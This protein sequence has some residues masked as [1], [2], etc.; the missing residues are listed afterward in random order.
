MNRKRKETDRTEAPMVKRQRRKK[1]MPTP[2]IEAPT[3]GCPIM[4]LVDDCFYEICRKLSPDDICA[5]SQTCDRFKSLTWN[6]FSH[7][8]Q[9]KVMVIE[10]IS[11]EGKLLVGPKN[12]KYIG[13]FEN[14]IQSVVLNAN[15]KKSL[16]QLYEIYHSAER[17]PITA[18]KF[19]DWDKLNRAKGI[20][21]G[22]ILRSVEAVT[23]FRTEIDGDLNQCLLR[24][25]PY[26]KR[27]TLFKEFFAPDEIEF[28]WMEETYENLQY[29]AW[30]LDEELPVATAKAFFAANPQ[31]TFFSLLASQSHTL[32]SLLAES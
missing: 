28:D 26:M 18:V 11:K 20:M 27:L 29:F 12:E 25:L 4:S 16:K 22:K 30:H 10:G 15:V 21:L 8:N 14:H 17:D 7:M 2:V 24:H 5:L 31:V 32:D 23:L 6:H 3:E 9:S 19:D 1:W 13:C